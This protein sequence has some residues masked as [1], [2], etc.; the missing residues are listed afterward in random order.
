M[1]WAQPLQQVFGIEV[2]ACRR[3]GGRP[4]VMASI[5]EHATINRILGHPGCAPRLSI[6]A[7]QAVGGQRLAPQLMPE[8]PDLIRQL[9]DTQRSKVLSPLYFSAKSHT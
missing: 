5:E 3:C 4:K 6:W 1:A 9:A 7:T 8:S 2:D